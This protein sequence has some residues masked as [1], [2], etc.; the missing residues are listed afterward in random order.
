MK[1]SPGAEVAG[2]PECVKAEKKRQPQGSVHPRT[3][4]KQDLL[5]WLHR[6][7]RPG[8]TETVG[9][10]PLLPTS[11][12]LARETQLEGSEEKDDL[13]NYAVGGF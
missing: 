10:G 2:D 1:P 12:S 4:L 8:M 11:T 6:C 13:A 5:P 9:L 3:V 7:G